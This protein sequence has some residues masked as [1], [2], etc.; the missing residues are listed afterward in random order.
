MV[1]RR[2]APGVMAKKEQN[3]ADQ[4]ANKPERTKKGTF[5]KGV[6]GNPAGRPK[7]T[8]SLR[9]EINKRLKDGD[10]DKIVAELIKDAKDGCPKARAEFFDRCFG[11]PMTSSEPLPVTL[12]DISTSEGAIE[13]LRVLAQAVLDG[14][15]VEPVN[16]VSRITSSVLEVGE[17]AAI[18]AR[19][20]EL[21]K[22]TN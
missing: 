10:L 8:I 11:K 2:S 12:P 9:T 15:T 19:L 1:P 16:A 20:D 13:A 22:G 4:A 3:P 21:E 6:S 14:A 18:K 5:V 7:G 17:I